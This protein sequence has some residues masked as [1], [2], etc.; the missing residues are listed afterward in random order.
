M[1]TAGRAPPHETRSHPACPPAKRVRFMALPSRNNSGISTAHSDTHTHTHTHEKGEGVVG[2]QQPQAGCVPPAAVRCCCRG[3]DG[4]RPTL[5]PPRQAKNWV[6][7]LPHRRT[8]HHFHDPQQHQRVVRRGGQQAQQ[9]RGGAGAAR[10]ARFH[11]LAR[12]GWERGSG[13]GKSERRGC[14]WRWSTGRARACKATTQMRQQL[15][16]SRGKPARASQRSA[17]R[18]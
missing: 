4:R 14:E 17:R 6:R 3:R 15:T 12:G 11:A 7:G 1:S 8:C 16:A 10:P 5:C 18:H 9:L 2:E 13:E